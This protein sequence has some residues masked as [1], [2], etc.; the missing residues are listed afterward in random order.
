MKLEEVLKAVEDDDKDGEAAMMAMEVAEEV[1]SSEAPVSSSIATAA[2]GGEPEEGEVVDGAQVVTLKKQ[3]Q[4]L[5]EIA[6]SRES[7]IEQVR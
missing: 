1:A 5:E 2:V 4:D 7:Q 6:S 3:L